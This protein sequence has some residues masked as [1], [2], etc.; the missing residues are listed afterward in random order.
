LI[1]KTF[2]LYTD[3]RPLQ[4][5]LN[6][7]KPIPCMA[8]ARMQRWTVTLASYE[9]TIKYKSGLANCN[10]DVLSHLPLLVQSSEVPVPSELVL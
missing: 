3:H 10:A 7:S 5:L 8:S 4:S 2:T 6:E 1:G 9:Y